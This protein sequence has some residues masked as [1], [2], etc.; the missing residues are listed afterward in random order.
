MKT[1]QTKLQIRPYSGRD[2]ESIIQLWQKCNLTRPWNNPVIDIKR[3]L[4][5]SPELFLVGLLDGEVIASVMGGYDGHRGCV[6][7]LAVNPANQKRGF[8]RQMMKAVEDKFLVLGCPKINLMIRTDNISAI[9]FYQ[10]L[11]YRTDDV[12]NMG[13]RLIED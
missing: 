10:K 9:G 1:N 5:V 7:Y 3:K 4:E 12:I 6:Y 11:G 13:K 8:G 2:R